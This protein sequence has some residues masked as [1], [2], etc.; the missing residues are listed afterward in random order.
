ME[1]RI[2]R[3]VRNEG[4]D[5]SGIGDITYCERN[6]AAACDKVGGHHV[7]TL[8]TKVPD[9]RRTKKSCA[10][11]DKHP[12]EFAPRDPHQATSESSATSSS[13]LRC[14]Q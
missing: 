3:G 13:V 14:R 7:D 8:R 12:P 2:G 6:A 1:D 9:Q 4:G 5:G 10:A 11:G